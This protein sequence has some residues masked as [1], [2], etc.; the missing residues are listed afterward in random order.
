M[1]GIKKEI[2]MPNS[3]KYWNKSGSKNNAMILRQNTISESSET[4]CQTTF[5]AKTPSFISP[6]SA[7]ALRNNEPIR[8]LFHF[9]L[10]AI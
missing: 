5:W 7:C 9:S 2:A 1:D 3:I 8:V 6:S 10:L 4:T